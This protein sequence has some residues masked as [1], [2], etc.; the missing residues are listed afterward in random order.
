M[1]QTI[2]TI[3]AQ[4]A[5]AVAVLAEIT[6]LSC[7]RVGEAMTVVRCA[8]DVIANFDEAKE[9][10]TKAIA[11]GRTSSSTI[12]EIAEDNATRLLPMMRKWASLCREIY[13]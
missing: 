13:V 3:E 12:T 6:S 1:E 7:G 5:E 4:A 9:C 2:K 11:K 10:H 8:E